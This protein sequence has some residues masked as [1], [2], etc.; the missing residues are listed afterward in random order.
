MKHGSL[1]FF[2]YPDKEGAAA[3]NLIKADFQYL[4][5]LGFFLSHT[6]SK[7]N[8][9]QIQVPLGHALPQFG[10]D[11]LDQP[12]PLRMHITKGAA[13]EDSN[14][15]PTLYHFRLPRYLLQ[16]SLIFIY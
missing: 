4:A 7:I 8:V 12:V 11:H 2:H 3:L 5:V 16:R 14:S 1:S 15:P 13:D 9:N 10:E 6:S